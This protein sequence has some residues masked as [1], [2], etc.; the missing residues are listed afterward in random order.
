V[1]ESETLDELEEKGQV[2][3]RYVGRNPNGSLND[4]AGICDPTGRVL[5]LMPHPERHLEGFHHPYWT[6]EGLK[7]EGDGLRVFRNAV[8]AT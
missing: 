3:F 2:V 4:I 5:G 8:S 1:A 6:R 7:P